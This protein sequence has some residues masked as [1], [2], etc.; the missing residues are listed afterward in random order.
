MNLLFSVLLYMLI[1]FVV[2]LA[3]FIGLVVWL[4]LELSEQQRLIDERERQEMDL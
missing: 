1:A 2:L 3:V 4:S